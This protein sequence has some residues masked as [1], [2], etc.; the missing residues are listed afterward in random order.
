MTCGGGE[1]SRRRKIKIEPANGGKDCPGLD[2]EIE[3]CGE[4]DCAGNLHL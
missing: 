4:I 2:T 1:R 3:A